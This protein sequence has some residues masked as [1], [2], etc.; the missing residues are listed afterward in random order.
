MRAMKRW[1]TVVLVCFLG[2]PLGAQSFA[3]FGARPSAAFGVQ[4][5]TD[6]DISGFIAT[7]DRLIATAPA[8]V[9]RDKAGD[10]IWQFARRL[11]A[12]RLSREQ[13]SRVLAHLDGIARTRPEAAGLVAG[14]RKMIST[15][16]VGKLAPEVAGRDLDGKPFKLSDYRGKVVLLVF[17]AE[18][19]AICHAQ[20]PYERFLLDKYAKWP[21][22]VLGVQTGSSRETARAAQLTS[23][24][25]HRAWWD[26]S[27]AGKAGGPIAATWNV[28][29]WPASYLIDADGVIQFVDVR[30]ENLLIAV[31]QLL[32]SQVDR[33]ARTSR[34]K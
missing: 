12:G 16:T 21:F 26:E 7:L 29:G 5:F 23:P 33:D 24:V 15:L 18:W 27:T 2:A 32:E 17:S 19:C 30:E 11:Q 4:A 14:P 9:W 22:A 34:R 25:S 6:Q 28:V 13:E 8:A 3:A 10:A 20:A 31:R 1:A